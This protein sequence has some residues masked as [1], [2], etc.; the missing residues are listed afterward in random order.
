MMYC[1]HSASSSQAPIGSASNHARRF[2]HISRSEGGRRA[3]VVPPQRQP[4]HCDLFHLIMINRAWTG[5]SVQLRRVNLSG[6]VLYRRRVVLLHRLEWRRPS[7]GRRQ[8]AS[9]PTKENELSHSPSATAEGLWDS[10]VYRP[11]SLELDDPQPVQKH[12]Q[13]QHGCD[14]ADDAEVRL[15]QAFILECA[16]VRQ[17]LAHRRESPLPPD[18]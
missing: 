5:H 11:D 15:N 16:V 10:S 1:G 3:A 14:D 17:R 2:A 8:P 13:Y 6:S 9:N 12:Y 7:G 4:L 18:E